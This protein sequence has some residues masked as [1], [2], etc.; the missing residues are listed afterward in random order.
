[1]SEQ[2]WICKDRGEWMN[3]KINAARKQAKEKAHEQNKTMAIIKEGAIFK[4]V[5]AYPGIDAFEII[6]RYS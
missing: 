3:E 4:I 6:S 1:M 5:E 2:C